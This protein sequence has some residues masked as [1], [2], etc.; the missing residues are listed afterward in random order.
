MPE[1]ISVKSSSNSHWFVIE[2]KPNGEFQVSVRLNQLEIQ[3]FIPM[4]QSE[5]I[6]FGRILQQVKPLFPNY[7]FAKFDYDLMGSKVKWLSG[8]KQILSSGNGPIAVTEEIIN[9]IKQRMGKKG[10]IEH[11]KRFRPRQP[12]RIA[13]G[14]LKDFDGVFL[15]DMPGRDRVQ[16]LL[17]VLEF[18]HKIEIHSGCLEA[19]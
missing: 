17:R 8:I 10:V 19:V 7:I 9:A 5:T 3:S 11:Q 15:R 6:V 2:T 12:V 14:P 1:V 16:I 18:S 4:I 13:H